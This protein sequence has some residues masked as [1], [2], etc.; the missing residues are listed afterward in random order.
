MR[1][2]P[3]TSSELWVKDELDRLFWIELAKRK[4]RQMEGD[5][6]RELNSLRDEIEQFFAEKGADLDDDPEYEPDVLFDAVQFDREIMTQAVDPDHSALLTQAM[7]QFGQRAGYIKS[8]MKYLC[9]FRMAD[10]AVETD[11]QA[12]HGWWVYINSK[13]GRDALN[14]KGVFSSTGE[15]WEVEESPWD[16][17]DECKQLTPR[18]IKRVTSFINPVR[19]PRKVPNNPV[20]AYT[21][22]EYPITINGH[23][24][25]DTLFLALDLNKPLPPIRE[26]ER[27]LKAKYDS[28]QAIRN[29]NSLQSGLIPDSML[30]RLENNTSKQTSLQHNLA[31]ITRLHTT[32][33]EEHQLMVE[34]RS[35]ASWI[36]GLYSWDLASTGLTDAQA[37]RHARENLVGNDGKEIYNQKKVIDNLRRV[38]RPKIEAYEPTNLPWID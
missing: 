36:L 30:D 27:A 29:W 33:P 5:L 37:C 3:Y 24:L 23:V 26:I 32:P 6:F 15:E 31:E 34:H 28:V 22:D 8:E 13:K 12:L 14:S 11:L 1:T 10:M 4:S 16:A 7:T 9:G 35:A 25:E 21:T 17:G 2:A 19:I 38:V 18:K 20:C